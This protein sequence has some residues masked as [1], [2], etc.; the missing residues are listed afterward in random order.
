MVHKVQECSRNSGHLELHVWG[1]NVPGQCSVPGANQHLRRRYAAQTPTPVWASAK[2]RGSASTEHSM[3][4]QPQH[5]AT[6]ALPEVRPNQLARH[7]T[8]QPWRV[9]WKHRP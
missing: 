9:W 6:L 5:V 2:Q 1:T 3:Q 8:W 7:I 4:I